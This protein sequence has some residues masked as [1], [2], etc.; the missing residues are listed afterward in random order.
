MDTPDSLGEAYHPLQAKADVNYWIGRGL[1]LLGRNGEALA[2]FEASA[3]EAGDFT[4]MAVAAHSPISYFRGLS[5]RELGRDQQA[6]T[7]FRSMLDY[8]SAR[9]LAPATIDYFATS[10]PNLLVFDEN[11]EAR[12]D[13]DADLIAALA[14]HGL[15]ELDDALAAVSRTLGF[16]RS[17]AHAIAL[18]NQLQQFSDSSNSCR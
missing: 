13:A 15:G 4:A 5:L 8:A 3:S 11:Q 7:V 18:H 1:K 14:Y 16:D 6:T 2:A 10:L 12:R 17:I 9:K